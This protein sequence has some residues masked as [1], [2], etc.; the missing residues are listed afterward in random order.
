MFQYFTIV[1][2][3]HPGI[4][5]AMNADTL[6]I[7]ARGVGAKSGRHGR[8]DSASTRRSFRINGKLASTAM[9]ETSH[10]AA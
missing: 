8:V 5:Q 6:S 2:R 10:I 9:L 1:P 7:V 3:A 4:W